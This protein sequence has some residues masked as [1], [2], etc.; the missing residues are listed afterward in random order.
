MGAI[1]CCVQE[2]K[3]PRLL[4]VVCKGSQVINFSDLIWYSTAPCFTHLCFLSIPVSSDT[5]QYPSSLLS[6]SLCPFLLPLPVR[7]VPKVPR[8]CFA[9][10][11]Q[12]LI[13]CQVPWEALLGHPIYSPSH[14]ILFC[15]L[16]ITEHH[17]KWSCSFFWLMIYLSS[18]SP[19]KKT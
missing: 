18:P 12:I 10:S 16:H 1:S 2:G 11:I 9:H 13:W 8:T 15:C 14:V 7:F 17:L 4:T 5:P 19:N 3:T 6:K